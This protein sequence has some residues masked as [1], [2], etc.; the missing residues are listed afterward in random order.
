[1]MIMQKDAVLKYGIKDTTLRSKTKRGELKAIKKGHKIFYD[2][3]DIIEIMKQQEARSENTEWTEEKKKEWEEVRK[4]IESK[5]QG[6]KK[7]KRTIAAKS[8]EE[9]VYNL[10]LLANAI[11]KQAADDY[12]DA[13]RNIKEKTLVEINR[14]EIENIEK[15][16][17]SEFC[18]SITEV[19]M[20]YVIKRL[21]E[22]KI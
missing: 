7:K 11:I 20:E 15:F 14:R 19:D 6:S 22:E 2:E 1:M 4:E 8:P 16:F 5:L 10:S 9:K 12:R 21:R 13:K 3:N 17:R 18:K